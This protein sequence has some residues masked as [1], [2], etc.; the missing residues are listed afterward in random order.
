MGAVA[1][2]LRKCEACGASTRAYRHCFGRDC[3]W[4]I[5]AICAALNDGEGHHNCGPEPD[6]CRCQAGPAPAAR[7]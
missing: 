1:S 6:R 7:G 2:P 5:C 4:F 3:K